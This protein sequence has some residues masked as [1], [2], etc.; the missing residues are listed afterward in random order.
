MQSS[1]QN[2]INFGNWENYPSFYSKFR[3]LF[4]TCNP[5]SSFSIDWESAK[6]V[7]PRPNDPPEKNHGNKLYRIKNNLLWQFS[8]GADI[9]IQSDRI[10]CLFQ[11]ETDQEMLEIYVF[12]QILPLWMEMQGFPIMH[13]SV[14]GK[15]GRAFAFLAISGT[16]KSSLAAACLN[17]SVSLL[18]DDILP[19]E[20]MNGNFLGSPGLPQINLWPDQAAYFI[21]ETGADG[22]PIS[23]TAKK[24]YPISAFKNGV[25]CE[26]SQPLTCLYIPERYEPA[27]GETKIEITPVPAVEAV[28]EL[29]RYSFIP[30]F[31]CEEMGWQGRRMEFFARLVER[32][33]VR[34]LR[35]PSGFEYLPA[36]AEAVM[37][38][39][40]R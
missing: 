28:I 35:Y 3:T 15:S 27:G 4:F 34:R 33:P 22:E 1:N 9:Y 2:L 5:S 40:E 24:R 6:L 30:V 18:T 17:P 19:I 14:L 29:L 11:R 16:G 12:T 13:A 23:T 38:D 8:W 7:S 26:E 21:G 39:A 37:R 25:F 31:I 20:E 10:D 32:V 36:V